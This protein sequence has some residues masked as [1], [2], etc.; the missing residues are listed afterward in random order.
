MVEPGDILVWKGH[1]MLIE[2]VDLKGL[3]AKEMNLVKE[4]IIN[5][6]LYICNKEKEMLKMKMYMISENEL[7]DLVEATTGPVTQALKDA[8]KIKSISLSFACPQ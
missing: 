8:D 3:L 4:N 1:A 6:D 5:Y 2:K 7:R